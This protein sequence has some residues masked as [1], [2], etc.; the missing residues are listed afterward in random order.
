MTFIAYDWPTSL[1]PRSLR[2]N[3]TVEN[4]PRPTTFR[5]TKSTRV[6]QSSPTK[7]GVGGVER[8]LRGG[9]GGGSSSCVLTS[10]STCSRTSLALLALR[11]ISFFSSEEEENVSSFVS[12]RSHGCAVKFCQ[13]FFSV[14]GVSPRFFSGVSP[15]RRQEE[16][17][18]TPRGETSSSSVPGLSS[19]VSKL[20]RLVLLP[21]PP[22][23]FDFTANAFCF[24]VERPSALLS[25]VSRR[26]ND[27]CSD[28][29]SDRV[30]VV[31][32]PPSV[33]V[34]TVGSGGGF[35]SSS[36]GIL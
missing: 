19:S 9:S 8:V 22:K 5:G 18:R 15:L 33:K 36:L 11:I 26:R 35:S 27:R 31:R 13:L 24:S 2:T 10:S 21:P 7:G 14:A 34:C 30:R 32:R 12:V 29:D 16:D 20:T 28:R 3:K 6:A 25:R 23:S 1:P 4:E 17:S